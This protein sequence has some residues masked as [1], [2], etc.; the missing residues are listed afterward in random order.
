MIS[1]V[2]AL[3]TPHICD[4]HSNISTVLSQQTDILQT[5]RDLCQHTKVKLMTFL[6]CPLRPMAL[7]KHENISKIF[8]ILELPQIKHKTQTG[9]NSQLPRRFCNANTTQKYV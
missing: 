6:L 8:E 9:D 7:V 2:P 4:H 3:S 1:G 5:L